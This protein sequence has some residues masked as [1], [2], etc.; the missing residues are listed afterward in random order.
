LF[1]CEKHADPGRGIVLEIGQ[2]HSE[3]RAEPGNSLER[4]R[5]EGS[6]QWI[7]V[8]RGLLIENGLNDHRQQEMFYLVQSL[9]YIM[10]PFVMILLDGRR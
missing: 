7:Q 8:R 3:S 5:V 4:A 6:W 9:S 1:P 10:H 2:E